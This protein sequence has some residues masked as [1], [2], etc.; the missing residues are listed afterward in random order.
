M[1]ATSCAD[2][3]FSGDKLNKFLIDEDVDDLGL[4]LAEPM[5]SEEDVALE[6]APRTIEPV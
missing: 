4:L 3:Y 6:R 5:T 1:T 2:C